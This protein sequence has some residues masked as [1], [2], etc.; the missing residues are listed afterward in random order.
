MGIYRPPKLGHLRPHDV[1]ETRALGTS[2][3]CQSRYF[4]PQKNNELFASDPRK[5]R[6]RPAN[7]DVLSL[8]MIRA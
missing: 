7:P 5:V 4:A 8:K 1:P 3:K 2:A 6:Y